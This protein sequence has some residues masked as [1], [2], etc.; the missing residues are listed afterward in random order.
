[1]SQSQQ[2][3]GTTSGYSWQESFPTTII[4]DSGNILEKDILPTEQFFFKKGSPK[5]LF[6]V[7]RD[8][9]MNLSS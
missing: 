2:A 4:L 9:Q 6:F 1:M 5:A 8:T 3:S 7:Y